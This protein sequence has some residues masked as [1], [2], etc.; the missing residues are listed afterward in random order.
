MRQF[1]DKKRGPHTAF[2]TSVAGCLNTAMKRSFLLKK[3][4]RFGD[5]PMT[6]RLRFFLP[7]F[8]IRAPSVKSAAVTTRSIPAM[9]SSPQ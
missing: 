3:R 5:Y 9:R 7:A 1:A 4:M 8:R 6:T 2:R